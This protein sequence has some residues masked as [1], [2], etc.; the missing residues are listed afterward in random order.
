M[1]E[2]AAEEFHSL[3]SAAYCCCVVFH[4]L[5]KV[6]RKDA[7]LA[8]ELAFPPVFIVLIE[9]SDHVADFEG[10]FVV[11]FSIVVKSALGPLWGKGAAETGMR[12]GKSGGGA[13]CAHEC[14]G[15]QR[16]RA[17]KKTLDSGRCHD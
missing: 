1:R 9:H 3:G 16:N 6:G 11:F 12:G 5:H 2:A 15:L 7:S 13:S 4:E 10:Q 17:V 14:F 8:V